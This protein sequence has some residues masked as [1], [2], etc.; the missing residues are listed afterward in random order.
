MCD[1]VKVSCRL[2]TK[3][4]V[5]DGAKALICVIVQYECP[6]AQ[7]VPQPQRLAGARGEHEELLVGEEGSQG[8]RSQ[9][10]VAEELCPGVQLLELR[11]SS[12]GQTRL[13]RFTSGG[14]ELERL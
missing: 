11:H 13:D 1:E 4:V 3:R 10:R 2:E 12:T 7:V 6:S 14:S 9:A 5:A 8:Q